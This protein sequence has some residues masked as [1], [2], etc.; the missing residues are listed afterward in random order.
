MIMIESVSEILAIVDGIATFKRQG[1]PFE[2]FYNG[3]K[4]SSSLREYLLMDIE[5][6]GF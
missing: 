2:L 3:T 5:N 6:N 4:V 1:Y